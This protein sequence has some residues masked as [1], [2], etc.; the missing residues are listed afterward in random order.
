MGS[1][2][3]HDSIHW[4]CD[5]PF[6]GSGPVASLL[7]FIATIRWH[8]ASKPAVGS[9]S[10]G[11]DVDAPRCRSAGK[12]RWQPVDKLHRYGRRDTLLEGRR[13][14]RRRW[15]GT[16]RSRPSCRWALLH[17]GLNDDGTCPGGGRGPLQEFGHLLDYSCLV[18]VQ[19]HL[20]R[21]GAALSLAR[22]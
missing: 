10:P 22:G 17:P 7:P 13:P 6:S 19:V 20:N 3:D 14:G 18:V 15:I 1:S 5:H 16:T 11:L 21:N 2:H 4:C 12:H 8:P 9:R